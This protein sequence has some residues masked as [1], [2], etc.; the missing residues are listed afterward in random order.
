MNSQT[1]T[2]NISRIN[3]SRVSGGSIYGSQYQSIFGNSKLSKQ[4]AETGKEIR[5]LSIKATNFYRKIC[6][7]TFSAPNNNF[8][9][10]LKYDFLNMFVENYGIKELPAISR[11]LSFFHYFKSLNLAYSDPNSKYFYFIYNFILEKESDKSPKYL[12]SM[13]SQTK[14]K[15]PI[16]LENEKKSKLIIAFTGISRQLKITRNLLILNLQSLNFKEE[17]ANL[18]SEGIKHNKTISSFIFNNC[19]FDSTN[20]NICYEI[21]MNG[22]L[23]HEKIEILQITNSKLDDK[24]GNMISRLI[25]RQSQRRDQ[26]IW[27][28]DL[29]NEK[30]LNNEFAKGLVSIDL[31][32]NYLTSMSSESITYSLSSDNYIRKLIL[33]N[34]SLNYSDCKK[35][36][37]LLKTNISLINVDLRGNVRIY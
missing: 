36:S 14:K 35:F 18:L 20:N 12:K 9:M 6:G 34:N 5:R 32:G 37:N 19:D 3:A 27:M 10:N 29:R 13:I 26:V 15:K 23:S 2:Y 24:S 31:S 33:K 25:T 17:F 11:V 16:N 4:N 21:I 1:N 7:K 22:M 8:I 30:P 28:Y